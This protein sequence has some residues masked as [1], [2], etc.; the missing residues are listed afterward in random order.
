[1]HKIRNIQVVLASFA[2]LSAAAL[3]QAM[4]PRISMARSTASLDLEKVIPKEFGE[5]K[6]VPDVRI[7]EPPGSDTL[8]R[9]IYSQEIGRGYTDHDGHV[10]MLLIAYGVSQSDR[11]QLHRPE[12]CYAAQGFRVSRLRGTTLTYST[13]APPIRLA[14]LVAQREGRL[15]PV[16]YWMRIG[17]DVATGIVERQLLRVRYG[18]HGLIPDGAL[19]RVSTTGV[20]E[21]AAYEI[22]AK[23]IRALL[24]AID[25]DTRQFLVGDATEERAWRL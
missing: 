15:E 7:V 17:N 8:S 23:F 24:D 20:T 6:L 10:I 19:V 11:L 22:E 5:W 18:L 12:I 21:E 1:L 25:P 16:S 9:E 14:Q 3:A 4:V 13:N 2:I